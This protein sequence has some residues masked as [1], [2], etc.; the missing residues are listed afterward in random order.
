MKSSLPT[1]DGKVHNSKTGGAGFMSEGTGLFDWEQR[2]IGGSERK[3]GKAPEEALVQ[4]E[5]EAETE[6]PGSEAPNPV[7]AFWQRLKP[8]TE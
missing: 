7:F 4:T 6:N 3:T 5:A 8:L 2:I 1:E